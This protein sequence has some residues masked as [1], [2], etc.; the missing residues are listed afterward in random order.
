MM[1][2]LITFV[3]ISTVWI[4]PLFSGQGNDAGII[5]VVIVLAAGLG[6]LWL[7]MTITEYLT[8]ESDS[9]SGTGEPGS[10]DRGAGTMS[11]YDSDDGGGSE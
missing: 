8:G 7:I 9:S 11:W 6:I 2:I 3:C 5:G 4:G 1:W 10:L